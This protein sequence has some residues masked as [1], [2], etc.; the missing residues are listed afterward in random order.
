M[1]Y[2][3]NRDSNS[4]PQT[5]SKRIRYV[6]DLAPLVVTFAVNTLSSPTPIPDISNVQHFFFKCQINYLRRCSAFNYLSVF[7]SNVHVHATNRQ[8]DNIYNIYIFNII[9]ILICYAYVM[10]VI[11]FYIHYALAIANRR[12][13]DVVHTRIYS[14]GLSSFFCS[15][16]HSSVQ[17]DWRRWLLEH[18]T[19]CFVFF[20]F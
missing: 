3:S 4:I 6:I 18:A 9:H 11:V 20:F 12:R 19:H 16:F 15:L 17:S 2:D 7:N 5:I 10:H 8:I 13:F 1:N 14:P